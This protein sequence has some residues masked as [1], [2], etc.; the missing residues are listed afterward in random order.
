MICSTINPG[1]PALANLGEN[2]DL[3]KKI[4]RFIMTLFGSF[5]GMKKR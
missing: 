3:I 5:G 1:I 4:Y 2:W